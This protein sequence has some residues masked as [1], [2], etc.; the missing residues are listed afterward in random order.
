MARL[1]HVLV[2]VAASALLAACG[3][4]SSTTSA[5]ATSTARGTLADKPPFRIASLDA[6]TFTAKLGA[7]TSGANL[8]QVA[9]NPVCGV[10]FYYIKYW[11]VGGAGEATESSGALLIPT[12]AAPA[13][14]GPRPILLYAHGTD[15][16]KTTNLADI[17]NANNTEGALIAASF[18]AQGYIVVASNYAG[19]DISTLGYH[20]YINAAQNS[21]E[22]IDVL[23]AAR[24]ALPIGLSGT[25]SDNGKL[26]ITGY[27]EGGYVAMATQRAIEA[28]GGTVTAAAPMSG[29]YAIEAFSDTIFFGAV[30]LGATVFTPLLTESYQHAYGDIYTATTDLYTPSF[31]NG[32]DT[33]LPSA[34]PIATIVSQGLLP[35]TAVFDSSTPTVS[36]PGSPTLSAELTLGLKPPSNAANPFTPLFDLGFGTPFLMTDVFR[37]SYAINAA[38][39]VDGAGPLAA[40]NSTPTVASLPSIVPSTLPAAEQQAIALAFNFRLAL[41]KNDLR[42]PAW[43]PH[44]PTLLCGGSGDPT[45]FFS[46]NTGTMQKFWSALPAGL[47]NVLDLDAV[48]SGSYAGLQT[49]FQT[50]QASLLAYYLSAAGGGL[51]LTA[52]E[53]Q[54]LQQTHSAEAPFC[55]VAARGFFN[56]VLGE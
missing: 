31:A 29:P 20:P 5:V 23:A 42:N 50:A 34:T 55:S 19:Y 49:G 43:E 56:T 4:S 33:L 3:G 37:V 16:D 14:S 54:V 53:T 18:A 1:E 2:A 44:S 10:D 41:N 9:G 32:I 22:M 25:T 51:S 8:L 17:T 21:N 11:T 36:V 47:V 28:A 12:G 7:T 48:P 27:S 6:P 38:S 46:V 35:P 26:L 15:T 40:A 52:A 13:C 39:F 45:V 30:N 24:S